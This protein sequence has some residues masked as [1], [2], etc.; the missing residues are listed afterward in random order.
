M[1]LAIVARKAVA[2]L[3]A[4]GLAVER[5]WSG[6]FLTALEMPGISLSLL[7]LDG[8]RLALLDAP[9]TAPAWPG[10]GRIGKARQSVAAT[11]D[12]S[13]TVRAGASTTELQGPLLAVAAALEQAEAELTRLDSATGDGDLGISMVRAAE[14]LRSVAQDGGDD[15]SAMLA[16]LAARLRRA[17]GGSSGP[18]YATALLRA[19][20]SLPASPGRGDWAEAF[21]HAVSAVGDLGGARPGDRTMVDALAPA[22]AAMA[23]LKDSTI[24]VATV[25]SAAADAAEKAA[26]STADML[27]QLGRSSY[28]GKRVLGTPDPGAVAVAIWLRGLARYFAGTS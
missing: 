17:V 14:A 5:A 3:R 8:D 6:N 4:Q 23:G 15:P 12:T 7:R 28:L 26:A 16:A 10:S 24:S 25:V 22:V 9:A 20:R 18:F 27:P 11:T 21:R 1:E 19:A 2:Q 13:Q